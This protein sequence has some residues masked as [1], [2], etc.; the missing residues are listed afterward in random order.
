MNRKM[1]S[2]VG[3]SV[4]LLVSLMFAGL[5]QAGDYT[6]AH[7]A[8]AEQYEL[9]LENEEVLVLKMVLAPGEADRTHRHNNETVYFERGGELR[10]TEPGGEVVEVTVPDGHVMWHQAWVHQVTNVGDS[11]VVAIIVESKANDK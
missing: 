1:K 2:T 8:S 6:S 4:W 5:V 10:I 7:L 11:E 3:A 9:L